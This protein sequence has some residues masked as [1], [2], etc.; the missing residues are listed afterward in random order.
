VPI[1]PEPDD[2]AKKLIGK[3]QGSI[4]LVLSKEITEGIDAP[5]VLASAPA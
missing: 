2:Y 3:Q 5:A 4:E 1:T